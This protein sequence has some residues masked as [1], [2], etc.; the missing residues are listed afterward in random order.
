LLPPIDI[1]DVLVG[2]TVV[3]AKDFGMSLE[4]GWVNF[5]KGVIAQ[6]QLLPIIIDY[7]GTFDGY[8]MFARLQVESG[9]GA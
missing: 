9:N 1:L 5:K 6:V 3:P 8:C 7:T 4:F 2:D